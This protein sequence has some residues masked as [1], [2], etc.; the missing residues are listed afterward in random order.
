MYDLLFLH[1]YYG[2][3]FWYSD[4]TTTLGIGVGGLS[5]SH[6][7]NVIWILLLTKPAVSTLGLADLL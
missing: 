6:K 4:G 1:V 3:V 5:L 2:Y 7:G